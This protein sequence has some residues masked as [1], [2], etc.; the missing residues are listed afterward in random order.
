MIYYHS[1]LV[2]RLISGDFR[3][4]WF[5]SRP[6]DALQV[7]KSRNMAF[8]AI[9][10]SKMGEIAHFGGHFLGQKIALNRAIAAG[11][12]SFWLF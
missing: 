12:S 10:G 11:I 7:R 5:A 6:S 8:L 2:V 3:F 1:F 9:F 4:L